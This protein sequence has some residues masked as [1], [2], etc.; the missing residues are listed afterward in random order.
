VV[1]YLAQFIGFDRYTQ[2]N[3]RTMYGN[4]GYAF[5]GTNIELNLPF[6][7]NSV[8]YRVNNKVDWTLNTADPRALANISNPNTHKIGAILGSC[9]Q[10][11]DIYLQNNTPYQIALY[12]VDWDTSERRQVVELHDFKSF[13]LIAPSQIVQSFSGSVYAIYKYNASIRIRLLQMKGAASVLS[14]IFFDTGK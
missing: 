5:F 13:D 3:W 11:V 14:A 6:W 8:K 9:T 2:G 4:A 10:T 1:N 12:F 7:V